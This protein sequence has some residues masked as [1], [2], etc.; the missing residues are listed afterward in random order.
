V[1]LEDSVGALADLVRQGKVRAIGLCEV[2]PAALALAHAIHPIA[3]VQCEYA[4]WS[5]DPE[6]G[7]LAACQRL[8]VAL[9]A[10][11]PLGR[12]FLTGG[13]YDAAQLGVG[14]MRH[15]IPRFYEANLSRNLGLYFA[16]E[17]VAGA[18]NCH[19]AQLALAWLLSQSPHIIPIPGSTRLE[20]IDMNVAAMDLRLGA[21]TLRKLDSIFAPRAVR[22]ARCNMAVQGEMDASEAET[23]AGARRSAPSYPLRRSR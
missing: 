20:H 9:I 2:S 8:D 4:L 13:L 22:G 23:A 1:P 12:G 5:R 14:D 10:S 17:A 7:L 19:P 6:S 3:A 18:L 11:A 16:L 21:E 15:A